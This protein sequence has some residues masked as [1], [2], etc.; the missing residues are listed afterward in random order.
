MQPH[1]PPIAV[2]KRVNPRQSMMR[3]GHRNE[4]RRLQNLRAPVKRMKAV[5]ELR[6]RLEM[7]RRVPPDIHH[8]VAQ[9]P[10]LNPIWPAARG[11]RPVHTIRKAGIE[12]PMEPAHELRGVHIHRSGRQPFLHDP[13]DGNVRQTELLVVT[14]RFVAGEVALQRPFDLPR[15]GFM[16]LDQVRVITIHLP[17]QVGQPVQYHPRMHLPRQTTCRLQDLAGQFRQPRL[18]RLRKKRLHRTGMPSGRHE[19]KK[20][21]NVYAN[22][23]RGI[24]YSLKVVCTLFYR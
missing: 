22:L 24:N 7:R 3:G 12:F 2:T 1:D 10:W 8:K 17:N 19:E 18:P 5:H 13:L 9:A 21:E 16:P 6:Q 14:L 23:L 15:R 20:T 4:P 11:L